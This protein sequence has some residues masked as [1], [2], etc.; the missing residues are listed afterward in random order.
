MS[1]APSALAPPLGSLLDEVKA[2]PTGLRLLDEIDQRE[3]GEGAAHTDAALRLFGQAEEDV[4]VTLYRDTAAW[5]PYCQKVWL[6]LEEKQIPFRIVKINM[7]SYGDKPP[8]FLRKVPGGLL[9][10][11]ELDGQ[12][13]TDSLPIMATLDAAF[14]SG[15][16]M[17]PPQGSA[18][19]ERANTLL[20][21][22][23]ELFSAWCRLTFQPGKGLFDAHERGF[24]ESLNKVDLALGETPGP[25]FLGGDAPSLVDL[26][27][28]SHVERM[29]A[30]VAFWKGIRMR[31][32]SKL[33]N[34]EKWLQAF[35]VRPTYMATKSD[36]YTH[37]MDI[38]PQYGPGYGVG[39]AEPYAQKISGKGGSWSWPPN[40]DD[41]LAI[42]PL[43]PLLAS[44]GEAGARHEA[45]FKL[46]SNLDAVV[47]FAARGSG[48]RGSKT[49]QA[50]LADPYAI[51][52]ETIVPQVDAALR[53]VAY[54]LLRGADGL[55][56]GAPAELTG[57]GRR[58]KDLVLCLEYLRER[59]GVPRDM[60]ET[61]AA[62][63]R[64]HLNWAIALVG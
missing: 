5:C 9:P 54:V 23:R 27:Y 31:D 64:A 4:R 46:L 52:D 59:I 1:A 14:D 19:R 6:L 28:V 53:L 47:R 22:E 29:V 7:R 62:A 30:S 12:L 16:P 34:L 56:N 50:P 45:A 15:P 38:P 18:D 8:S 10:A 32:A 39:A 13:M 43:S 24:M 26:Q 2:T 17:I 25:W 61:A 21:L 60:S 42:E 55:G 20:R 33:P 58:S 40:E 63:L 51:A 41:P 36:P 11:I 49:F 48:Q 35:E 44:Q 57:L 37:V 3:R